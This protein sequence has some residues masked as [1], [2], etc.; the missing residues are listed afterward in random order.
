[1]AEDV[2]LRHW[3]GRFP[4]TRVGV[5]GDVMLDRYVSGQVE[6]ISPEAPI[7]VLRVDRETATLGGAGNVL[8]NLLALGVRATFASVVGGDGAAAEVCGLVQAAGAV[9]PCLLTDPGRTTTVK[10]RYLSSSQQILRTDREVVR[11]LDD[12]IRRALIEAID[13]RL[14][15][16]DLLVL[17]DYGKGVLGEGVAAELIRRASAA[18]RPVIVDPKGRDFSRYRGA[19]LV[20]PNRAELTLAR[21]QDVP[22]GHEAPHARALIETCGLGAILVTLGRDGMVLIKAGDDPL[23]L[24]AETRDVFDVSGAG[25]TVVAVLAAARASGASLAESAALANVAAGLVVG[26]VGTAVVHPDELAEAVDRQ[27]AAALAGKCLSLEPA[28]DRIAGWRRQGLAVGFTNGCFDL[29]HPGHVSLLAQAKATCDRLVVGLNA[30]AS[31]ARLKGP[32][33][34]I[35]TEHAR[36]V[37]LSSLAAVDLVLVFADD[38]PQRLI[39]AIRPDVLIKGADYRIEDVVGADLVQAAGGRVVLA[40]IEPGYSTSRTVAGLGRDDGPSAKRTQPS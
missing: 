26:K 9:E 13:A 1:M 21:G 5:A 30:D 14:P 34:P 12:G 16:I 25:D 24:P 31:V 4:G 28:L 17:S 22:P 27:G 35:Q 38:T 32:G 6:R 39:A 8:R 7:P 33:R 37:V 23:V 29:L 10:T 3:I 20:T 15:L 18:G 40:R 19:S 2:P 36:A 11:P